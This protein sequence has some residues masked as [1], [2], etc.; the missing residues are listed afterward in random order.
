MTAGS[1]VGGG[2]PAT[3]KLRQS[4]AG[5]ENLAA[6]REVYAQQRRVRIAALGELL[7]EDVPVKHAA[8][9]IGISET[10]AHNMLAT[11]KRELGW[12]AQ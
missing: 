12:Q 2:L 11:M 3:G 1:G 6:G 5:R 9:L 8:T 10:A 4:R 7:A